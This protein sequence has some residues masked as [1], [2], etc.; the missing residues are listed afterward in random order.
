MPTRLL[1][2]FCRVA[3]R[4]LLYSAWA[5]GR[6]SRGLAEEAGDLQ[7]ELDAQLWRDAKAP[8]KYE[9]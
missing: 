6:C 8:E 9:D 5:T 7:K 2:W 3:L 1:M 4:L